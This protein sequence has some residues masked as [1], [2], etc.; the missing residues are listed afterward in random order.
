MATITPRAHVRAPI[1]GEP[2]RRGF[3]WGIARIPLRGLKLPLG[4]DWDAA[5]TNPKLGLGRSSHQ[6]QPLGRW[7]ISQGSYF[8]SRTHTESPATN[9]WDAAATNPKLGLGR[10]SHQ[11]R[12]DRTSN[13]VT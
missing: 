7:K 13:L 6:C 2:F 11:C 8:R 4:R 3:T 10:S 9:D 5:A 12:P 1:L